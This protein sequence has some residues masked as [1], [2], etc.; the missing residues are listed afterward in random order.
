MEEVRDRTGVDLENDDVYMNT[1][2][3]QFI[4]MVVLKSR[5]GA[6]TKFEYDAV[7]TGSLLHVQ[8]ASGGGREPLQW[9][10]CTQEG[11]L[12]MPVFKQ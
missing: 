8:V 2:F 7:R 10:A 9:R 11:R 4:R 12:G 3:E 6:E 1:T 5:G